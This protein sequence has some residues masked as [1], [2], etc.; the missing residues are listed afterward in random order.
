MRAMSTLEAVGLVRNVH[1]VYAM[2]QR[3]TPQAPESWGI[4]EDDA[5][6][7]N[8]RA[9]GRQCTSVTLEDG[10]EEVLACPVEHPALRQ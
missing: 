6:N 3:H 2:G 8:P 9:L 1:M 4:A 5:E 7:L 10:G